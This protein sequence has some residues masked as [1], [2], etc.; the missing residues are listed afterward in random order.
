MGFLFFCAGISWQLQARP[1]KTYA[2]HFHG[3]HSCRQFLESTIPF[4][5]DVVFVVSKYAY[6]IVYID[7]CS[8]IRD[9]QIRG[10]EF[11]LSMCSMPRM[12]H[13][14]LVSNC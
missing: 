3:Y 12:N 13:K 2:W 6:V 4:V 1:S 9:I 10:I 14:N 8:D 5:D 7:E 11:E